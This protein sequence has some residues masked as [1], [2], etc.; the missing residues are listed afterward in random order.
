MADPEEPQVMDLESATLDDDDYEVLDRT[1]FSEEEAIAFKGVYTHYDNNFGKGDG[2]CT[3]ALVKSMVR[4]LGVQLNKED[5]T[6]MA[7]MLV[8]CDENQDGSTQFPEFLLLINKM[9]QMN[10][11]GMNDAAAA[12]VEEAEAEALAAEEARQRK[13]QEKKN[14]RRASVSLNPE[15]AKLEAA[16]TAAKKDDDSSDE[17]G[18]EAEEDV[19]EF[20]LKPAYDAGSDGPYS[21]IYW[22][23]HKEQ[24]D[25]MRDEFNARQ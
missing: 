13:I 5:E 23:H 24:L 16:A 25:K 6:Q 8:E 21:N 18:S 9:Q 3:P 19:D 20:A 10:F 15:F 17:E 14:A 1:E 22:K 4:A 2:M 7:Q 12:R 11:C